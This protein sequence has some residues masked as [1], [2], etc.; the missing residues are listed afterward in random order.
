MKFDEQLAAEIVDAWQAETGLASP[1]P[2]TILSW[3][4]AAD[5]EKEIF[6][7]VAKTG[8]KCYAA[9]MNHNAMSTGQAVR[10]ITN[11]LGITLNVAQASARFAGE[12]G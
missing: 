2:G 3:I 1:Y 9:A 12:L 7:A 4:A 10:Y 6:D 11:I 8:R 5:S